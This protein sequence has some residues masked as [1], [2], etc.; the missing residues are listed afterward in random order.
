MNFFN[1]FKIPVF[2]PFSGGKRFFQKILL[3][4]T[5]SYGSLAPWKNLGKTNDAIPEKGWDR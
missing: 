1:K 2:G 5:I 3:L 4:Q